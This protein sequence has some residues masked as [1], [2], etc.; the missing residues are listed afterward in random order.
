MV[1]TSMFKSDRSAGH[2]SDHMPPA[3]SPVSQDPLMHRKQLGV[4]LVVRSF[5]QEC[6]L[7]FLSN[8]AQTRVP[9]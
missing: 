4:S 1:D 3:A 6:I 8:S 2:V 7:V 5:C 9:I